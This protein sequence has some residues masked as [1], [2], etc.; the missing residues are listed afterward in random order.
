MYTEE[1]KE[2]IK[3]INEY[4]LLEL[5]RKKKLSFDFVINYVANEKY[6]ITRK[7]KNITLETILN[8]QPHLYE[9]FKKYI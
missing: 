9:E 1:E 8:Y 4:D 7:E 6:Q 5:L 2:I 3:N